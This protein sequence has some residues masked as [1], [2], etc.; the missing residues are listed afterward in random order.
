[1]RGKRQGG[2]AYA[3]VEDNTGGRN[4]D[5]CRSNRLSV[6]YANPS[7]KRDH[8]PPE[9]KSTNGGGLMQCAPFLYPDAVHDEACTHAYMGMGM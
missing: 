8:S 7:N 2:F 6:V 9:D 4:L 3:G 5:S 1:M